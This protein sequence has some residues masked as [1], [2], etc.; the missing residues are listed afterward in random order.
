MVLPKSYMSKVLILAYDSGMHFWM[1]KV[2]SILKKCFTWPNLHGDVKQFCK[3][4][5][6]CQLANREKVRKEPMIEKQLM[7]EPHNK[8][9]W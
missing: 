9:L 6:I 2:Q 5:I 3:S 7:T 4:C 8:N 1:R